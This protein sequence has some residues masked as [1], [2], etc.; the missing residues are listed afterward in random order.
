M[1]PTVAVFGILRFPAER[2]KDVLPHLRQLVE[3][4]YR[5]DGCIACHTVEEKEGSQ[6]GPLLRSIGAQRSRAELLESLVNPVAKIAPGY[7]LVSVTLKDGRTVAGTLLR[8]DPASVTLRQTSGE[9]LRLNRAQVAMQTPPV[10]MMPPM[11]GILT[12]R[13]LRDVVAYLASLKPKPAAKKASR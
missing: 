3:E 6:V 11:L 9:E 8:E 7:G 1:N 5:S 4:T 13:E 10:S 12:P 2:V